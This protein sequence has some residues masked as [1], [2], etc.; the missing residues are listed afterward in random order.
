MRGAGRAL[1]AVLAVLLVLPSAADARRHRK[2]SGKES[3]KRSH[4]KKDQAADPAGLSVGAGDSRASGAESTLKPRVAA[5]VEEAKAAL[6]ARDFDGAQKK[7]EAAYRKQPS[8]EV[9]FVLGQVAKAAGL[10][11]E[12]HDLFRR[13]LADPSTASDSVRRAEAQRQANLSL[14]EAGDLYIVGDKESLVYVNDR[15]LGALPL[16]LPLRVAAGNLSVTLQSGG[17]TSRGKVEVPA[18]QA[19][20]MRFDEL[21]GAVLVSV[22]PTVVLVEEQAGRLSSEAALVEALEKGSQQVGYSLASSERKLGACESLSADCLLDL[23]K[24]RSA[25]YALAV[26]VVQPSTGG[27]GQRELQ[28]QLWDAQVGDLAMQETVRCGSFGDESQLALVTEQVATVLRKGRAR[29]RGVLSVT[30]IPSDAQLS[31][32]GRMVGKTPW[33]GSVF[34]GPQQV[35]LWSH[36]FERQQLSTLVTPGQTS[37]LSA[38]LS[39]ELLSEPMPY[40]ERRTIAAL[41]A[42]PL[43]RVA[44]GAAMMGVGMLLLGVGGSALAANGTCVPPLQPPALVCRETIQSSTLGGSLLGVGLGLSIGGVVMIAIPPRGVGSP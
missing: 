3:G 20:E 36:G 41:G 17:R 23:A 30:S 1:G 12:S 10:A 27:T 44:T 13:Y 21:T 15:L 24:Q 18:G 28:L 32:S 43:W 4:K 2:E 40:G 9:L 37:V 16:L 39:P 33:K 22:P 5:L 6:A 11:V 29:P 8:A 31:L 42:R 38:L 35:E 34:V 7:A 19:R 14:P 25:N 26:R